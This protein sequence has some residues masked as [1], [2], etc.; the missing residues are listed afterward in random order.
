MSEFK[1]IT[2]HEE[3]VKNLFADVGK[4]N[5]LCYD[6]PKFESYGL[7]GFYPKSYLDK[8]TNVTIATS[9]DEHGRDWMVIAPY[10]VDD[11]GTAGQKVHDLDPFVVTFDA[12]S[13]SPAA[14]GIVGYHQNFDN[15]TSA[16]SGYKQL[17]KAQTVA[18]LRNQINTGSYPLTG[19]AAEVQKALHHMANLFEKNFP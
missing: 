13:G 4:N 8:C 5:V 16:I 18:A 3:A 17:T 10:R 15:R 14:T 2:G 6:I 1:F 12:N 7:S 11:S 9:G 19:A